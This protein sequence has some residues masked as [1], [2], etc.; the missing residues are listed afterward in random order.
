MLKTRIIP[1]VLLKNSQLVKSIEFKDFR[2]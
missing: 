2:T 1:C